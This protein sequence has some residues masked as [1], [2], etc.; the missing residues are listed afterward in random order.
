MGKRE[1]SKYKFNLGE[2]VTYRKVGICQIA[3]MTVQN[4]AGQG[5]AEYY[6]LKS[7]Y[8]SNTKVFVPVASALEEEMHRM[9]SV[10]EINKIIDSSKLVENM[11]V[12]DCRARANVFE[13]IINSGD[14]AKMLWL[15]KS[16]NEY[17]IIVE[18]Q[19]KKMKAY[20]IKYL[21]L[22]ENI[23]SG[24]FAFAL[25]LPKNQVMEYINQYLNK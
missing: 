6:V 1:D 19:K 18:E 4:F 23:I 14:K 8:D 5:K 9:L 25:G 10:D 22:A 16:V 3:E 15:I 20:D 24:D 21:S 7:V 13:E 11:W 12:D 2:Y 17:K